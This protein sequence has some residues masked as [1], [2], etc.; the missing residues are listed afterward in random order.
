MLSSL[1][2]PDPP[3]P[4]EATFHGVPPA[5]RRVAILLETASEAALAV[6]RALLRR[7][8]DSGYPAAD[9]PADGAALRRRLAAAEPEPF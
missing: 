6:A 7:L 8:A 9:V 4:P 5:E 1:P 2:V 3:L